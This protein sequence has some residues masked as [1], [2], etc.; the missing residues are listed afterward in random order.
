MSDASPNPD[1]L[2]ASLDREH[3]SRTCR[4][5]ERAWG[6][7]ERL[8]LRKLLA[9]LPQD[10]R[11]ALVRRLLRLEIE[12]RRR[13]GES[14]SS[15]E[16][17]QNLP[18]HAAAVEEVFASLR[19]SL[20]ETRSLAH[21]D[22]STRTEPEPVP[23]TGERYQIVGTLG[24][25]AFATVYLA[26]DT[27]LD[28]RVALKVPHRHRVAADE[29]TRAGASS[30]T[31]AAFEQLKVEARR[32]ARIDHPGIVPVYDVGQT[33]DG[34]WFLVSKLVEGTSLGL[35]LRQGRLEPAEAAAIVAD[36][37][38]ALLAAHVQGI[39]HRDVKPANILL[40]AAGRAQ[41]TDFGL[42]L[43]EDEQRV[44]TTEVS[45]SPRYMAPEQ[46]RGEMRQL[47][48]RTDIWAL[49]VVLYSALTGRMPF[50]GS[51]WDELCDEIR[52]RE[53]KPPRMI[54]D[55]LPAELERIALKCL[56]KPVKE[57]YT[58]AADLARDLR[59]WREASSVRPAGSQR[60]VNLSLRAL[61]IGISITLAFSLGLVMLGLPFLARQSQTTAM[62]DDLTEPA[63]A[64]RDRRGTKADGSNVG[65]SGTAGRVGGAAGVDGAPLA[66][67]GPDA[68]DG[69]DKPEPSPPPTGL[70]D[71]SLPA[72]KSLT[73]LRGEADRLPA[74]G[75]QDLQAY[76]PQRQRLAE[77]FEAASREERKEL[78]DALLRKADRE[79]DAVEYFALVDQAYEKAVEVRDYAQAK[80][81]LGALT[82][83]FQIDPHAAH[84]RLIER[85]AGQDAPP[86]QF[87]ELAED[88]L[89]FAADAEREMRRGEA[90]ALVRLAIM[91][92]EKAQSGPLLEQARVQQQRLQ[93]APR[94]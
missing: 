29:P 6:Q 32:V 57:R 80:R 65:R 81:S 33:A 27:Q 18:E 82:F 21:G 9:G 85:F 88:A 38:E 86:E 20:D 64:A 5:F 78:V 62:R 70:R 11:E 74:P 68:A 92:A 28:R 36:A 46:T 26:Q 56:A 60:T 90:E 87:R 10:V 50:D 47:D 49:G 43:H 19:R 79:A 16:Y 37:A 93:S 41:V 73:P 66:A 39:V 45:G 77:D 44:R 31:G 17:A 14:P 91:L 48:G 35:R 7:G 22:D 3:I 76:E 83:R 89:R 12:L 34:R 71:P 54:D 63:A 42:A 69:A 51:N 4:E 75:P 25:G 13:D 72:P 94:P 61:G 53:P 2:H 30:E 23:D 1:D 59:G 84:A 55:A 52:H 15:E 8:S 67:D 24:R 40:T 58:N